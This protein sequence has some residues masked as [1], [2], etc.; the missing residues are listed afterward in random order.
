MSSEESYL[1]SLDV[2]IK[3]FMDDP[4]MN[5]HLPEGRRVMDKRQHHVIFSNVKEVREV[6]ALFLEKLHSRQR[7]SAVV[8]NIADI[9]LDFVSAILIHRSDIGHKK[10]LLLSLALSSCSFL[11]SLALPLDLSLS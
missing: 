4:G 2:L 5:P 6:S 10:P 3:H 1:R 8:R 7:E 11:L 9:I